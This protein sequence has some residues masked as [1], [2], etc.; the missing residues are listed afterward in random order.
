MLSVSLIKTK[1]KGRGRG[2]GPWRPRRRPLAW[3][4]GL[5]KRRTRRLL[6]SPVEGYKVKDQCRYRVICTEYI[7]LYK[8]DGAILLRSKYLQRDT[9]TKIKFFGAFS[10]FLC[11]R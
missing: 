4:T 10:D 7:S 6:A 9:S 8:G 1:S 2:R 5:G 11:F 3:L